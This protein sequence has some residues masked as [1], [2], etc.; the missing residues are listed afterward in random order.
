MIRLT[1][2]ERT[3]ARRIHELKAA[4]GTHSPSISTF[5]EKV[6]EVE[7]RVDA[8]FL[9]NPHA[10]DLVL[11]RL[12]KEI[13]RTGKLRQCIELYPSQNGVIAERLARQ[14]GVNAGNVFVGNGAIEII[15]AV[16]HN[17]VNRKVVD[18]IPTFSSYYEFVNDGIPVS[19]YRLRKE[20]DFRLDIDEYVAFIERERPD[21]VVLINPNNPDGSYLSKVD[22]R[23][24]LTRLRH[25]ETIV[26]DESFVHFACE[27]DRERVQ[28]YD[29]FAE[30][31]NLVIVKSLSKDFGVAGLRA[32]YAVMA[33]HRVRTLVKH[34]YL[35]NTNGLAEYFLK[36][37]SSGDFQAEYEQARR[38]YLDDRDEIGAVLRAIPQIN[39]YPSNANFFLVE[40]VDGS[41]AADLVARLLIQHGVY[42]RTGA[43]KIGLEGE[44][45]RIA[46]RSR[47]ENRII[48]DALRASFEDAQR[49][50]A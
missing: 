21:L 13:I 37:Y 39:V 30:N 16:L 19:F 3:L 14:L 42:V 35:W 17:F 44:F 15:E 40:V 46:I 18:N 7:L 47:E 23:G 4:A 10:T 43:D 32:G 20:N 2:K 28:Y 11:D 12:E 26:L 38:R 25:V 50:A 8:C 24:L 36:L 29:L 33:E 27:G 22:L 6:P 41:S 34:G 48:V 45:V 1:E 9:S 31:P 49:L 5:L